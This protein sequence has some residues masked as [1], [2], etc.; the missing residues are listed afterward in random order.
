MISAARSGLASIGDRVLARAAGGY[1]LRL[2]QSA[3]DV[4]AAQRLRFEVFNI[5]LNEGLNAS[6]STG[7]DADP[8]D[9]VCDHLLVEVAATGW[10]VGTYRL[11]TGKSAAARRGYYSEQEFDLGPFERFRSEMIE[12]GRACVHAQH[13]NLAVLG[14]LWKG[15]AEYARRHAGRYLVGCSSLTSQDASE[16]AAMYQALAATHLADPEWR[17]LPRPE[18]ACDLSAPAAKAPRPPR[19]LAAYLSIGARICGPPAIDREFKTIDFLTLLDL[20]RLPPHI[21]AKYLV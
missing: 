8:F 11:Q 21:I 17:T 3:D 4:R 20:K 10:A 19:L 18:F 9:E 2:A 14:L 6:Y 1:R 16:G 7:L 13:R 5:E 15:I 12:L